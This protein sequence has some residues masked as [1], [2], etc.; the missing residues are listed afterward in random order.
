MSM[1]LAKKS[2]RLFDTEKD[3]HGKHKKSKKPKA[4]EVTKNDKDSKI[5]KLLLL[6]SCMDGDEEIYK[7]LLKNA[8]KTKRSAFKSHSKRKAPQV[9]KGTESE[10]VFTEEDFKRFEE[11]YKLTQTD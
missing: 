3:S 7:S 4:K 11:E 6:N 2:M 9:E 5:K 1:A 8:T 10:G